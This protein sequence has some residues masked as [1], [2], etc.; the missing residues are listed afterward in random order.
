MFHKFDCGYSSLLVV[1]FVSWIFPESAKR[2][3]DNKSSLINLIN[4]HNTYNSD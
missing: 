3:A 1:H 4:V 2:K